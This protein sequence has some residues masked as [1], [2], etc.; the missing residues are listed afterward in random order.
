MYSNL[1]LPIIQIMNIL[2]PCML[3]NFSYFCCRL[4]TF[5]EINFF[6]NFR[7]IIRVSN[8]RDPEQHQCSVDPADDKSHHNDKTK[9]SEDTNDYSA[10]YKCMNKLQQE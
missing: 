1:Y 4:L 6:K 10:I 9:I 7:N 5:F 8:C 2:T 3:G